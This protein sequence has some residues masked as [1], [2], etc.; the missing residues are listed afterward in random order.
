MKFIY[1]EEQ[2]LIQKELNNFAKN[3]NVDPILFNEDDTT[4]DI[5]SEISTISMFESEKFIILKNIT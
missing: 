5:V 2:Y 4:E 3:K 1:G